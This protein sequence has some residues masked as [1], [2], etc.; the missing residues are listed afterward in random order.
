MSKAEARKDYLSW[1][2]TFMFMADLIAQRSK[3][4]STQTGA[5]IVDQNHIVLGMGYNGWPRGVD[6][7]AFPWDRE[8]GYE[9]KEFLNTKYPYI[10]HA[11]VN[12]IFNANKSVKGSVLYCHLFPCNDCAKAII[13]NR[14]TEVVYQ[15]DKYKDV[16]LWVASKK[17]LE[18][19]GIKYRQFVPAKKLTIQ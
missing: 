7:D 19:A 15:D 11:E 6:Q 14:I 17:L 8:G 4:P 3:D 12:A 18:A 1:D 2:E 16:D 5:V 10:V 13:Q 9:K